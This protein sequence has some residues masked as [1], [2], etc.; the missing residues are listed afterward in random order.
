[1]RFRTIKSFHSALGGEA[2]RATSDGV[3]VHIQRMGEGSSSWR[4]ERAMSR[5]DFDAYAEHVALY[6]PHRDDPALLARLVGNHEYD[7]DDIDS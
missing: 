6:D 4:T 7:D 3:T 1:M 2:Y 5:P